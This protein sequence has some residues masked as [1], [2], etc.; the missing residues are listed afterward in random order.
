[1]EKR[2]IAILDFASE[3]NRGDAAMQ[4]AIIE[5]VSSEFPTHEQNIICVYGNN[6]SEAFTAHFDCSISHGAII[7]PGLRKTYNALGDKA[8]NESHKKIKNVVNM[9]FSYVQLLFFMITGVYPSLISGNKSSF[10][11]MKNSEFVIWNGRNFRDRKGIGEIYDLLAML[12]HPIYCI[13]MNKKI[14]AIGVSIWPL[15]YKMSRFLLAWV[16]RHCAY[17]TAREENSLIYGKNTLGLKNVVL[18]PDLSYY[19]IEKYFCSDSKIKGNKVSLT[20]VDWQEDGM[21]VRDSYVRSINSLVKY[22]IAK[23]YYIDVVPQVFYEWEGYNDLLELIFTDVDDMSKVNFIKD[24]L[25][26]SELFKQYV[27]SDFLIAT[28]MHSAIFSLT[29]HTPIVAIPYDSGGK[30]AILTNMGMS[31]K[32]IINY[33]DVTPDKLV[34]TFESAEKD[35]DYFS[36]IEQKLPTLF[37]E[38]KTNISD[39]KTYL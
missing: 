28:R 18:K 8:S 6:Q 19:F 10:T 26:P 23:G 2:S 16:L 32:Y 36:R 1:M 38:V 11:R 15:Q 25:I 7:H 33:Q 39:I 29:H 9:F 31:D 27:N 34:S 20:L 35:A 13:F 12:L 17:V 22:L 24:N 14:F 4:E 5:M 30:W 37:K 3:M 21:S